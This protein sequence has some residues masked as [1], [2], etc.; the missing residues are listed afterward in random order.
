MLRRLFGVVAAITFAYASLAAADDLD[1]SEITVAAPLAEPSPEL[2][3]VRP[4]DTAATVLLLPAGATLIACGAASIL[5]FY[6]LRADALSETAILASLREGIVRQG[7][8]VL[9]ADTT[10][11][12]Y[13]YIFKRPQ[14][15]APC[16]LLIMITSATSTQSP[17]PPL[18]AEMIEIQLAQTV[19]MTCLFD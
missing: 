6:C 7:W 1:A 9:G 12:P 2:T 3:L 4:G 5:N 11:R 13:T 15:G 16:P 17:R 19:D 8:T 18:P 10:N 14:M